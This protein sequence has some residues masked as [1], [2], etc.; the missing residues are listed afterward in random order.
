M[1]DC[2]ALHIEDLPLVAN[3]ESD[4]SLIVSM[5]NTLDVTQ[6]AVGRLVNRIAEGEASQCGNHEVLQGFNDAI[7]MLSPFMPLPTSYIAKIHH[8]LR[9]GNALARVRSYL[10]TRRVMMKHLRG[11]DASQFSAQCS[12][13]LEQL[14][15]LEEKNQNDRGFPLARNICTNELVGK[16]NLY[17]DMFNK[18]TRYF[19][20]LQLEHQEQVQLCSGSEKDPQQLQHP[21]A[22]YYEIRERF[23][24]D[25]VGAHVAAN[26]ESVTRAKEN[27]IEKKQWWGNGYGTPEPPWMSEVAY[28]YVGNVDKYLEI[29][30]SKGYKDR[31]RMRDAWWTVMLRAHHWELSV[32]YVVGARRRVII[33]TALCLSIFLE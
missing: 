1:P 6:E 5:L 17:R 28:I 32:L 4:M 18:T 31:E 19:Q 33:L 11:L 27:A 24:L 3:S 13:V 23:Y 29:L 9:R 20:Q 21:Y 26:C 22:P 16:L 30:G 14:E 8:P 15:I 25:F 2:K 7:A 10:S 12:C